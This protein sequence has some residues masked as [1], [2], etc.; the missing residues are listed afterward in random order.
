MSQSLSGKLNFL[1]LITFFTI[2][3][4]TE[5]FI[6]KIVKIKFVDLFQANNFVF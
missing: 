5:R 4:K 6:K 2:S 3:T 1:F